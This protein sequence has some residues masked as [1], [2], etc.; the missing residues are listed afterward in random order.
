MGDEKRDIGVLIIL[1]NKTTKH[2]SRSF[3]RR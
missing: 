2:Q 3:D 1:E